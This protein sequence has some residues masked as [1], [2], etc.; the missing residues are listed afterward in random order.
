[1]AVWNAYD[2]NIILDYLNYE[3][4][5]KKNGEKVC[6]VGDFFWWRAAEVH[7]K[8]QEWL[9]QIEQES[10]KKDKEEWRKAKE[11]KEK[12]VKDKLELKENR[13]NRSVSGSR[14]EDR[15]DSLLLF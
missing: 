12:T 1:M 5:C 3:R 9:K 4:A 8:E 6:T 10:K 14:H 15:K 13:W 11:Q 2:N 7:L